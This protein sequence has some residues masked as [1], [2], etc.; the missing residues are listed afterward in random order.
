VPGEHNVYNALAALNAAR[1][2][3]ISDKISFKALSEYRGA[4]RRFE[5]LGKFKGADVVS[6]Y[7]HHPTEVRATLRAAREKYP[8]K[9]IWCVFQPH[10]IRR[11]EFLFKD[12]VSAFDGVDRIFLLDIYGVAGR[13]KS[14]GWRRINSKASSEKL[15]REIRKRGK[16]AIYFK[17]FNAAIK[18]L[19]TNAD[20]SKTILIMG[21]GDIWKIGK[22]L[23]KKD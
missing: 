10:Q 20:K 21:A 14:A 9:E 19:K 12:F 15:A 8:N 2:L 5:L 3:K 23:T 7:A 18:V 17:D 11:T 16:D 13:E 4:W 22:R 6:D 1:A